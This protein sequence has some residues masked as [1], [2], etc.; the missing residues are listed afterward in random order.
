MRK[1]AGAAWIAVFFSCM[2]A[3][4][5]THWDIDLRHQTYPDSRDLAQAAATLSVDVVGDR[6]VV[7]AFMPHAQAAKLRGSRSA[8]D[9][10]GQNDTHL[11]IY[12]DPAGDGRYAQVFGLNIADAVQ[13]GLY[14]EAGRTLDTGIN[15]VWSGSTTVADDG[16]RADFDIPLKSLYIAGGTEAPP[17][18]Y[19]E[20]RRVGDGTELFTTHDT[21]ADGA[22]L[23]CSAPRLQGFAAAAAGFRAWSLR[24]TAV[25]TSTRTQAADGSEANDRSLRYG[26]DFSL[27]P[28]P[29][30]LVA[31][32]Y[33][34]NFSDR[35]PDQP[36]LTK[37]VQF[38]PLLA[39]TRPFFTIGSDL[40]QIA[41]MFTVDQY[42]NAAGPNGP[43]IIDTRQM[44]NPLAA[45]QAV[46][47]TPQLTSKWLFVNDDGG[48]S[49]VLPGTYANGSVVTGKSQN[50]F[51]RGIVSRDGNDLGLTLTDRDYGAGAGANRVLTAD[52]VHRFDDGS[53]MSG[54]LAGAQ[55][56]ACAAANGL[57]ECPQRGGYSFS[58]ALTRKQDLLDAGV[59]VQSVS[60]QF[61]NDLGWQPQ[62]G[63][64]AADL[65]WWPSTAAGLP[66]RLARID[67]QPEL[68][69]KTDN[70][71]R[72]ITELLNLGAQATLQSGPVLALIAAPVSRAKLAADQALVQARSVDFTV[73]VSPTTAWQRCLLE[74]KAGE[75]PDYYNARAGH[76]YLISVDQLLA[77]SRTL[78]WRFTANWASSR[79]AGTLP[80]DGPSIRDGS[81][82]LVVNYQYESFSRLRWATQWQRSAGWNLSVAPATRFSS[83]TTAHT[84]AWIREPRVGFSYSLEV[85]RQDGRDNGAD[86]RITQLMAKAGYTFW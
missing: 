34:P 60:P 85:S 76:G 52:A 79:A 59:V 18:I 22:C 32:T 68:L 77:S 30:W 25:W 70:D 72:T 31:G 67:W 62:S 51:G 37:D 86:S 8:P 17:R 73:S 54:A 41:P 20:Y 48:G 42:I 27:Q 80:D 28:S 74:M 4:A 49:V 10:F 1:V 24:P 39:E 40:H 23:L 58:G 12:F 26:L 56:S 57:V 7:H 64:R 14:R 43:Q 9:G 44:A 65:W 15:F 69:Y 33:H 13:D 71:G 50:F 2:A 53:Q 45:V 6:L 47:R 3:K 11:S 35:D 36:A 16:W 81:A 82:L 38:S 75:L 21:S 83:T 19:A 78:S 63:Y 46:G 29:A 66:A 84:F 5:E 55:T 61:R